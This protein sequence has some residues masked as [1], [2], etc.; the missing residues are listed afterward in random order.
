[1]TKEKLKST[2]RALLPKQG[3][4]CS[5]RTRHPPTTRLIPQQW[6]LTGSGN[7][8]A[9]GPGRVSSL[10]A[11]H[12]RRSAMDARGPP[13]PAPCKHSKAHPEGPPAPASRQASQ[14]KT[15]W[16]LLGVLRTPTWAGVRRGPHC[17][18]E[19]SS[20]PGTREGAVPPAPQPPGQHT[21]SEGSRSQEAAALGGVGV[22]GLSQAPVSRLGLSRPGPL[23]SQPPRHPP[24]PLTTGPFHC[25]DHPRSQR[26]PKKGLQDPQRQETPGWQPGPATALIT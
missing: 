20:Q 4:H 22:H 24:V 26:N 19:T 15:Q 1:M 8:L 7:W 25:P 5:P 10:P 6:A 23:S 16:C 14:V 11:T 17:P 13:S 18:S 21:H 3:P 12:T 9:P 2:L